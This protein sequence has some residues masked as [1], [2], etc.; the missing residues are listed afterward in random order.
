M[1]GEIWKM[2]AEH[3]QKKY[4]NVYIACGPIYDS[5]NPKRIGQHKVAVPDRFLK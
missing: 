2:N 5:S 1:I 4:R 3:G